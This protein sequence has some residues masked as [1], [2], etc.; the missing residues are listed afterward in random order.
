MLPA[1]VLNHGSPVSSLLAAQFCRVLSHQV[2]KVN[3]DQLAEFLHSVTSVIEHK[4]ISLR[5]CVF[6]CCDK[7]HLSVLDCLLQNPLLYLP[8]NS[9]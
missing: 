2:E 6:S 7:R 4:F 5:L 1:E 3:N 9:T 8:V